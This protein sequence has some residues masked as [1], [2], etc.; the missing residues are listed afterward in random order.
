MI[1]GSFL[2]NIV[3]VN[4]FEILSILHVEIIVLE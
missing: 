4:S 1:W 2:E 3:S